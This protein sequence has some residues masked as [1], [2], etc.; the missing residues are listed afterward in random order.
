MKEIPPFDVLNNIPFIITF[1]LGAMFGT[2][3]T[4]HTQNKTNKKE[5]E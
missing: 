3:L 2:Y 1:I 5:S 4:L